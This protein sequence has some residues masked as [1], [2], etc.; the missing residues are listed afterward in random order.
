[1]TL[2]QAITLVGDAIGFCHDHQIA[3]LLANTTQLSGFP[4]PTIA[5]RYWIAQEWAQK[6]KGR[7]IVALVVP[8]EVADP[9]KFE[10]TA[11]ANAGQKAD[12]FTSEN[13]ALAWLLAQDL[14]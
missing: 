9:E 5:D 3:K 7:V 12:T 14:T 2:H 6:A 4:P 11:A 10:V 8:P 1:V 13:E